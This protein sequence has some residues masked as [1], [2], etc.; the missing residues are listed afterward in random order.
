[1]SL[2]LRLNGYVICS[3]QHAIMRLTLY[4]LRLHRIPSRHCHCNQPSDSDCRVYINTPKAR[5]CDPVTYTPRYPSSK[6][7]EKTCL[8][9]APQTSCSARQLRQRHE[10]PPQ[11]SSASQMP[12]QIRVS[13]QRCYPSSR[14]QTA[15]RGLSY[16]SGIATASQQRKRSCKPTPPLKSAC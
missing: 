8:V 16:R 9:P 14:Q 13:T 7:V 6:I 15:A 3:T 12:Q 10:T 4:G 11:V 5:Q 1:M 2:H